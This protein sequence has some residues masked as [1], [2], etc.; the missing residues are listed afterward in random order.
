MI[1]L[2]AGSVFGIFFSGEDTGQAMRSA[3]R[4]IYTEYQDRLTEIRSNNAHDILEMSG[5]RAEWRDVLAVYAVK[6]A[7]DPDDPQDVVGMNDSKMALLKDVFWAMND[8]RYRTANET[9]DLTT[10]TDDGS[11][12]IVE[13]TAPTAVTVLYIS[14]THKTAEDMADFYGFSADQR[15]QLTELLADEYRNMWSAALYGIGSGGGDGRIVEAALSQIGN[16]GGEPYWRW[17]GFG[18]RVEWCACFVSWCANECG[19]IE[20]GIIP[21]FSSCGLGIRWFKDHSLWQDNGYEPCPGD[22]VFFDWDKRSEGQ[23]GRPDHVGIVEKVENGRIYTVEGNSGNMC[24]ENSYPV[25]DHEI[26]GFGTP[27]Y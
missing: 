4:E 27:A 24:R 3:V 14:V 11:G 22:I 21:K 9:R 5:T 18:S 23:D 15:A 25:G 20:A 19:Y 6:A 12:N 13:T 17:Y 10:E 26:F 2:L 8:I 7:A 16:V 1:G